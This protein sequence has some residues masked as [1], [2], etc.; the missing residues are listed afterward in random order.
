MEQTLNWSLPKEGLITKKA[1]D[2]INVLC[3]A[4]YEVTLSDKNNTVKEQGFVGIRFDENKPF[5]DFDKLTDKDIIEWVKN[6]LGKQVNVIEER[7]KKELN[8]L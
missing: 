3:A 7:L 6:S 1:Q 2:K 5:I 8:T 4:K